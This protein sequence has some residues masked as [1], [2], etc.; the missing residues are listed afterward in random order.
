MKALRTHTNIHAYTHSHTHTHP[1]TH[2]HSPTHPLTHS[3]THRHVHIQ[4][5]LLTKARDESDE[6][7]NS[8]FSNQGHHEQAGFSKVPVSYPVRK[9]R[10]KFSSKS[11]ATFV[12]V[13][14]VVVKVVV[15]GSDVVVVY[16]AVVGGTDVLVAVY[17]AVVGGSD[18]VVVY[19][20]V[21]GGSDGVVVVYADVGG[22]SDVAVYAA[23]G[24]GGDV[25]VV[26]NL[27]ASWPLPRPHP[28][29]FYSCAIVFLFCFRPIKPKEIFAVRPPH[30]PTI[31]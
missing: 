17:A 9:T 24:G 14:V 29:V 20:A 11:L 31:N 2:T 22:G 21:V 19:A 28:L 25:V 23:V 10:G 7:K 15:G 16:A 13:Y 5:K 6:Y 18:V 1:L 26:V 4:A 27:V 3:H 30:T 8:S 12:A